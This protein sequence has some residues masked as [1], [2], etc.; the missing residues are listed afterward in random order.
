V[1]GVDADDS[2]VFI[3]N[4]VFFDNAVAI[5]RDS[6]S[7]EIM[8]N[9]FR[10][11]VATIRS[12]DVV[13]DNNANVEANCWSDNADLR[14]G[15]I[16]S[17]YGTRITLGD[18]R[19]VAED[20]RDFHLKQG[21]PCIDV[22]VGMDVIDNTV[23]DVGAYGGQLADTRPLPVSGLT[24]TDMSAG[25]AVAL[26]ASWSPNESYLVTHVTVPGGYRVHYEQNASG[27]PYAGTDAGGGT[28]ASPV[29]AGDVTTFT[30]ANLAPAPPRADAT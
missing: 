18:P 10:S 19:F 7:V 4:N 17:G 28:Q 26:A 16:D 15:G 8:N 11:N 9:I 29:D 25:G 23:A 14:A 1:T 27:A 6:I 5:R 30:L 3:A 22:G 21:S 20:G 12:R 24:L 2:D 13:V